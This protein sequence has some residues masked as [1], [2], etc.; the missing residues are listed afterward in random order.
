[1]PKVSILERVDSIW[2]SDQGEKNYFYY[3]REILC[4]VMGWIFFWHFC[5][6]SVR[7]WCL[8][9]MG[10]KVEFTQSALSG[11]KFTSPCVLFP[12]LPIPLTDRFAHVNGKQPLCLWLGHFLQL[13]IGVCDILCQQTEKVITWLRRDTNFIFECWKYLSQVSEANEWEILSAWEDKIRIS[14]RPC[15]VLFI[16]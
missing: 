12:N 9:E 7:L 10:N 11:V 13:D 15:N 2:K 6:G 14:K 5:F 4:L 8:E 16:L 1:M 3:K